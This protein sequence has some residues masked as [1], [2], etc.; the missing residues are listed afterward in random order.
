MTDNLLQFSQF[1]PG[2]QSA[3]DVEAANRYFINE[4]LPYVGEVNL[5]RL[6]NADLSGNAHSVQLAMMRMFIESE[7]TKPGTAA[8]T[9]LR[10]FFTEPD[11]TRM[12]AVV[13]KK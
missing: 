10:L 2:K 5:L 8:A 9:K 12:D 7:L 1:V 13:L 3:I 6:I 4:V 11:T